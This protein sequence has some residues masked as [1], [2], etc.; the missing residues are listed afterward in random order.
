MDVDSPLGER[1]SRFWAAY[2]GGSAV[3]LPLVIAD[4]G[5]QVSNGSVSFATTYRRMVDNE[6]GRP[7]LAE[8]EAYSRRVGNAVRVWARV[9]NTS[10]ATLS[11]ARNGAAVHALVWEDAMVG[12]TSRMVRAASWRSVLTDLA[13]GEVA[14]F[15][16]ETLSLANVNWDKVHTLVAVDYR[17]GGATGAYDMLQASVASPAELAV[18]PETLRLADDPGNPSARAAVAELRGPHVLS[19]TASTDSPWLAVTPGAG[20]LP[21]QAT[22]SLIAEVFPGGTQTGRVTFTAT[23]GD[24]LSSSAVV[25]VSA[26]RVSPPHPLRRRL[27]RVGS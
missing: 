13:P 10:S 17:P 22:V 12:V 19:W 21:A 26:E 27:R 1:I 6:L 9:T 16:L 20:A 2:R 11:F 8:V 14:T 18:A 25:V 15:T 5:H 24:G 23:S 3:Y 7:P 4:S